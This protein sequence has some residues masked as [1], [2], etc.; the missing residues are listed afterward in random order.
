NSAAA[1]GQPSTR[2]MMIL[3]STTRFVDANS[4]AMAAVKFA[5]LRKIDRASATA[6]YEHDDDA[7]PS[8]HAIASVRGESSGSSRLIWRLETTAWTTPESAKPRISAQR[9]SQSIAKAKPSACPMPAS[10]VVITVPPVSSHVALEPIFARG[11]GVVRHR[12]LAQLREAQPPVEPVRVLEAGVRPEHQP[13][14]GVGAA[15]REHLL[16]QR[17]AEAAAAQ[18]RVEIEAVDLGGGCVHPLHADRADQLPGVAHD[19]E[20][21]VG[22][23]VVLVEAEEIREF[24]LRFPDEAVLLPD[25]SQ[26]RDDVGPSARVA[27]IGRGPREGYPSGRHPIAAPAAPTP[28]RP[29]RPSPIPT[30][31]TPPIAHEMADSRESPSP[32]SVRSWPVVCA[33]ASSP[34]TALA[35]PATCRREGTSRSASA[36]RAIVKIACVWTTIAARPGGM[37]LAI[38]KNWKRNCPVKSVRPTATSARHGTGGRVRTT[39]GT[40][41]TRNRAA[42]SCGADSASRPSFVAT[43]ARPQMTATSSARPTSRGLSAGARLLRPAPAAPR[44]CARPASAARGG[45]AGAR[46]RRR[47]AGRSACSR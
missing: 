35:M 4:K 21:A 42:A 8:A 44:R 38:P 2:I 37:P 29:T 7:A 17:P 30:R 46:R 18:V 40:A 43:N 5:P 11:V 24:G 33:I 3:S 41:A 36:A 9:I 47:A 34:A 23:R 19:P 16:H 14:E 6:A 32:T 13:C 25:A 28:R 20:G 45:S 22:R 39:A 27:A 26:E 12:A 15:P 31:R 10:T 1:N